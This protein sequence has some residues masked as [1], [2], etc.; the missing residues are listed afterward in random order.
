MASKTKA[1]AVSTEAIT[2]GAYDGTT[3]PPTVPVIYVYSGVTW[4]RLVNACH[5]TAGAYDAEATAIRAAAVG[6]GM[7]HKI[8]EL[9]LLPPAP[10]PPA[11]DLPE[12]AGAATTIEPEAKT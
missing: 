10:P 11:P 1:A 2:I 5:D 4:P 8:E 3:N 9:G 7:K 6:D 12:A